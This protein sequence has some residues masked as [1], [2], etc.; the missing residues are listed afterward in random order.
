MLRLT[1]STLQRKATHH[2]LYSTARL[3][4]FPGVVEN[5]LSLQDMLGFWK[6]I[7]LRKEKARFMK[8]LVLKQSFEPPGYVLD[9]LTLT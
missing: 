9:A 6:S 7:S 1:P 8:P 4:I 5:Y 2:I 3:D